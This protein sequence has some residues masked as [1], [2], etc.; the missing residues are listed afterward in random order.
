M[1]FNTKEDITTW[2]VSQIN[3]YGIRHPDTYSAT[4]IVYVCPEIPMHVIAD[5]VQVRDE[6]EMDDGA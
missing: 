2:A 6:M 5:H 3:K 4:E 1:G